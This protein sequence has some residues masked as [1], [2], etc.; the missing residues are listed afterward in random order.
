MPE[1]GRRKPGY[2]LVLTG[3]GTRRYNFLFIL[4]QGI[5]LCIQNAGVRGG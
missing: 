2:I 5:F 4:Y 3:T 1:R